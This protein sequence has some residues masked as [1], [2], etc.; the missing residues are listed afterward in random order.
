MTHIVF[1]LVGLFTIAL[2]WYYRLA[3]APQVPAE[4][5]RL[6]PSLRPSSPFMFVITI[7]LTVFVGLLVLFEAFLLLSGD[8]GDYGSTTLAVLILLLDLLLIAAI[9]RLRRRVA[10][11]AQRVEP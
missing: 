11:W 3:V 6:P 10:R 9:V 2:V 4:I 5:Q 8:P 7:V 1:I